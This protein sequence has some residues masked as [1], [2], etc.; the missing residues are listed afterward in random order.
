MKTAACVL[1]LDIVQLLQS[2]IF[3][4]LYL[5]HLLFSKLR[6]ALQ[7]RQV[8]VCRRLLRETPAWSHLVPFKY[9]NRRLGRKY[10]LFTYHQSGDR[11]ALCTVRTVRTVRKAKEADTV[12][13][14]SR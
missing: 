11:Q 5:P 9:A 6:L 12:R 14:V 13:H 10:T 3:R 1:L 8:S 7:I 4:Q 2:S